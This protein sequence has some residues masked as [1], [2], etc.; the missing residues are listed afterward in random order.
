MAGGRAKGS[1]GAVAEEAPARARRK[2]RHAAPAARVLATGITSTACF[3]GVALLGAVPEPSWESPA[4]ASTDPAVLGLGA[5]VEP[6]TPPTLAPTPSTIH[7]VEHRSR[8]IYVDE[9]GN[10]VPAPSGAVPA[11]TAT[12]TRT[13]SPRPSAPAASSPP[14]T[15]APA[16]APVPPPPSVPRCTGSGC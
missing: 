11:H 1:L 14:Q 10:P 3:G 9:A 5:A 2:R 12:G 13:T 7:V 15:I 6:T 16:P 8:V 4:P